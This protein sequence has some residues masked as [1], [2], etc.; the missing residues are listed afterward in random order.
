MSNE[1]RTLSP[2]ANRWIVDETGL[3]SQEPGAS[4]TG[5]QLSSSIGVQLDLGVEGNIGPV[6]LPDFSTKLAVSQ[7]FADSA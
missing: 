7:R 2:I 3:C 1:H 5:V 6:S 4:K